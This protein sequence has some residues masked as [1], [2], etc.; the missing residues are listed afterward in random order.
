M[1]VAIKYLFTLWTALIY[2]QC[3]IRHGFKGL[4]IWGLDQ[5]KELKKKFVKWLMPS[6][7]LLGTH[8]LT[9]KELKIF[10]SQW[11]E[12]SLFS[13]ILNSNLHEWNNFRQ[14]QETD[15]VEVMKCIIYFQKLFSYKGNNIARGEN[16]FNFIVL[17]YWLS[18][19]N[20]LRK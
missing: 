4:K 2:N 8:S 1:Y 3:L 17:A 15:S 13:I 7:I 11:P 9:V 12:Q 6:Q 5:M 20:Q 19:F 10:I 14:G 16:H 18:R